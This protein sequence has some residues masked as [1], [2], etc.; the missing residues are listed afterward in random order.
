MRGEGEVG[1]MK[2]LMK[3]LG[4]RENVSRRVLVLVETKGEGR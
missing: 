4:K 2:G 3:G 1:I